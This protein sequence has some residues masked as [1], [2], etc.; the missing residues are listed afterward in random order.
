MA[1]STVAPH[2]LMGPAGSGKSALATRYAVAAA[3]QDEHVAVFSF[4]EGLGTL[5]ARAAALRWTCGRTSDRGRSPCGKSIRRSCRRV[6]SPTWCAGPSKRRSTLI[7]VDSLNGYLQ[8]MAQEQMLMAQLHELLAYLRQ[9]GVVTILVLAQ[10]G[11]RAGSGTDRRQLPGRHRGVDALLRIG[12]RVRK[13]MSVV[14]KR[15]GAHEDTI[16]EFTLGSD[17]FMVGPPLEQFRGVL[18]GVTVLDDSTAGP[19]E[20]SVTAAGAEISGLLVLAPTGRDAVLTC[21]LLS[22]AG[23]A[24][25][26]LPQ[27]RGGLRGARARG[28]GHRHR[29]RSTRARRDASSG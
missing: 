14:K 16:R 23:Y 29:R 25:A 27:R 15:G 21:E 19:G 2:V 24:T 1:G 26:S 7:I 8:A 5:F 20:P 11:F 12:R 22:K 10:H 18:S 6:N 13:A 3:E 17:G 4:D 28:G 9:R